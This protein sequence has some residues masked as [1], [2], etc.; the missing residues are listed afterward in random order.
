MDSLPENSRKYLRID[1]SR[2]SSVVPRKK[3][4]APLKSEVL[5]SSDLQTA[6]TTS[7]TFYQKPKRITGDE[8]S[9]PT[10]ADNS[11]V[12]RSILPRSTLEQGNAGPQRIARDHTEHRLNSKPQRVRAPVISSNDSS[13]SKLEAEI[14]SSIEHMDLDSATTSNIKLDPSLDLESASRKSEISVGSSSRISNR[15]PVSRNHDYEPKRVKPII[16][17]RGAPELKSKSFAASSQ[18]INNAASSDHISSRFNSISSIRSSV[19]EIGR[20]SARVN[21]HDMKEYLKS[22]DW[23]RRMIVFDTI[24]NF[25]KPAD[26]PTECLDYKSKKMI[27]TISFL[28]IGL[29]D[30]HQKIV[31]AAIEAIDI[32]LLYPQTANL[33]LEALVPKIASVAYSSNQN[34]KSGVRDAAL[35]TMKTLL[36]DFPIAQ[37][38]KIM[39]QAVDDPKQSR[40]RSACAGFLA[41]LG[42]GT[43]QSWLLKPASKLS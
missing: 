35:A 2:N 31:L 26:T 12:K 40:M 29:T 14:T 43:W 36:V 42:T 34:S 21:A 28:E 39:I 4:K 32:L 19:V 6:S 24:I 8:V 16:S 5:H 3:V 37:L 22:S 11:K 7:D 25:F 23:S 13:L 17:R 30:G 38:M 20:P 33:A 15:S 10:Q 1:K 41:D 9:F 18:L 27:N